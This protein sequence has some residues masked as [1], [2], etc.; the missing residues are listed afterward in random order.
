MEY[1]ECTNTLKNKEQIME[2]CKGTKMF[3][4]ADVIEEIPKRI[5]N[6]YSEETYGMTYE[7]IVMEESTEYDT[8]KSNIE[9]QNFKK[10]QEYRKCINNMTSSKLNMK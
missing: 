9:T 4:Y 7:E 8:F 3:Y 10:C 6:Q 2:L 5:V 1:R